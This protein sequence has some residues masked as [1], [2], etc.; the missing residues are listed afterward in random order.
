MISGRFVPAAAILLMAL[1]LAA[2]AGGAQT[3][4][5]AEFAATPTEGVTPLAVK[6]TDQSAGNVSRWN[7][8]FG[9]GQQDESRNPGHEYTTAGSFT[10]TLTV[11][12]PGGSAT[13]TRESYIRVTEPYTEFYL[14]TRDGPQQ[15]PRAFTA[16]QQATIGFGIVNHE[17]RP[18]TYWVRVAIGDQELAR[19]AP[20]SLDHLGLSEQTVRFTPTRAGA[21]QKLEFQ[22]YVAGK[23]DPYLSPLYVW[24]D[25]NAP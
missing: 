12:G 9:D 22:L 19:T 4:P 5:T 17:G 1:G 15:M 8:D 7:W 3:A 24:V 23:A 11:R 14:G 2:C 25:V 10:V 18:V 6:F 20:V 13:K 16:G 21:N